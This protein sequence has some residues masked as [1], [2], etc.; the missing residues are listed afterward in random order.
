[1][2]AVESGTLNVT[3]T[4]KVFD[5]PRQT[6]S[7]RIKGKH[8]KVG[9]GRK[10]ELTEDEKKILVDYCIFMAK[11]SHTLTVPVIKDFAWAMV[12]KSNRPSRFHPT[13]GPSWKWWRGFK[14]RRPE[15]PLHKPDNLDCDRSRMNNQV[16][17]DQFF[18][19][20][21]EE[22]E[23][24]GVLDKPEHIFNA[25]EAGIDL[26]ARSGKVIVPKRSKHAYSEQKAPS[27]HIT[28]MVCCSASGQVL[29]PMVIFEK[30]WPS[31]PYSRN[32]PDGCLFGKSAKMG[33]WNG[34]IFSHGL[35][36]F[37]L[38]EPHMYHQIF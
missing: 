25:D 5:I 34:N 26:N 9:G 14:K 23:S 18:K 19:L 38:L 17:M 28:S 12:R 3:E 30:N 13:D 27:D 4:S 29:Q 1:M 6:P 11:C 21:K 24:I 31:G 7:D 8:T 35:K 37:L 32:G 22:L 33:T 15:I 36:R 10:T 20:L 16:V 2:E